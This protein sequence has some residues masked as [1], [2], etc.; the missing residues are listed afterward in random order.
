MKFDSPYPVPTT[1]S[2][3]VEVNGV[4][5]NLLLYTNGPYRYCPKTHAVFDCHNMCVYQLERGED[6][7]EDI[8][9][10]W[11][12]YCALYQMLK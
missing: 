11:N 5:K 1:Q 2:F 9:Q 7:G 8:A 6:G 3:R 4:K 10:R 12:G